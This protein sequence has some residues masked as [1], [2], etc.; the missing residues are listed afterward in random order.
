M[1]NNQAR[2]LCSAAV[3]LVTA[4]AS[5]PVGAGTPTAYLQYGGIVGQGS[6]IYL[7]RIP[8]TNAAGQTQYY[9]GSITFSVGSS[10]TLTS[11]PTV[12][13]SASPSLTTSHFVAGRYFA[14][15][16][17]S[18]YYVLGTLTSGVGAGGATVWTWTEDTSATY[19]PAPYQAV[20]QTGSP[21]PDIAARLAAAKTPINPA[22]SYG[23]V[24][25]AS[26]GLFCNNGLLAAQ[27]VANTI[28][29][30]SYSYCAD[31]STQLGGVVLKQCIDAKCSNAGQ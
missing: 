17:S 21:A 22:Y 9:D 15:K 27:Q 6:T 25:V 7:S 16:S 31:S 26:G 1:R 29:L 5:I 14:P 28:T 23:F 3:G 24:A 12:T 13:L 20:W 2:R 8:V 19:N 11:P 10:G 30:L 18:P 4:L